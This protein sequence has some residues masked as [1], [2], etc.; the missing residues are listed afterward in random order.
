MA[1]KQVPNRALAEIKELIEASRPL[2]YIKS[3]EEER[4]QLL[5]GDASQHLFEAPV[6]VYTWTA[7]EGLRG[8]DGSSVGEQT[9]H[10]RNAIDWI[11]DYDRPALFNLRDFHDPLKHSAEVR[12]RM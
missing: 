7:T 12:R 6:P 3:P 11:I 5:L 10:P 9:V 1:A 2:I 8:Q 4:V